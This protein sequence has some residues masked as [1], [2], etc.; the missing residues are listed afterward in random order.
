VRTVVGLQARR[1]AEFLHVRNL[2]AE[3]YVG[4]VLSCT[5][6]QF[7]GGG[8]ARPL[9][10]TWMHDKAVAANSLTIAFGHAIDGLTTAVGPIASLASVV[11][12]QVHEWTASDTGDK[13]AVDAPDD[14]LVSGRLARGG[15]V[16]VHLASLAG[17]SS[18]YRFE[19]HGSEGALTMVSG[20]SPHGGPAKVLGAHGDAKELSEL[21]VPQD[22]WVGEA[23]LT[24]GQINVGKMWASFAASI[25]S[26]ETSF[27]P[28]FSAAVQHHKLMDT[29]QRASDTGQAQ[30]I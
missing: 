21:E 1:S 11:D 10:R 13:F 20:G 18:G 22:P 8:R 28:D 7:S 24:G 29:V 15:S 26:G 17:W 4:D 6:T 3:G 19:V 5:L 9:A 12:T 27:D 2:I 23:G 14:I 30:T 25:A 16:S